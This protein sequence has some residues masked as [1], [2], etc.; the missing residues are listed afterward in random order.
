M[1]NRGPKMVVRA[2]VALYSLRKHYDGNITFY[3]EDPTPPELDEC[4]KCF[5]CN[6]IHNKTRHD[7]KTLVRKSSLLEDP[8]YD[9]TLWMDLDT[10]TVA[11]IDAMFNYLIDKQADV[12]FPSFCNWVSSG[13]HISRR[14]KRFQGIAEDKYIKE[15]LNNHPSVNTGI[16]SFKKS[17]KWE[18]FMS[19]VTEL[20]R[21]GSE[22]KIF[23]PD[24]VAMSILYPSMHEWGLKSYICETDYNVSPIHDHGL[25]KD[26]KI[27]HFHGDKHCLPGVA[28]CKMWKDTFE[29]MCDTNIANIHSVLQYADKRLK[30]YMNKEKD[31]INSPSFQTADTTIVTAC[32]PHYCPILELTFE[33]WRKYKGVDNYPVIVFV[34][35]IDI[36]KDSRLDFLRL[37]NVTM[38]PWDESCM[39]PVESH[40]ELM[41]SAFVF[42]TA[43]HVKTDYWLKLDADSYATDDRPFITDDMKDY[44]FV[45]HKWGYSRPEMIRKLDEW[46]SGHWRKKLRKATPMINEGRIEGRRFYHNKR[47]NISYIQLHKTKFIKFC[48]SLLKTKRLPVPSHDT[49]TYFVCQRFD[50]HLM[51]LRNF[52]RH[53]GFTQ[54]KGK[55]GVEHIRAKLQEVEEM[56]KKDK[57]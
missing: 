26:P 50:P 23:I 52:K 20:A 39:D 34:N 29:E 5:N 22:K 12:C 15:A 48:V 44:A 13:H 28:L 3:I 18:K 1:F 8:P 27:L 33:N 17:D 40:R 54:G 30:I 36:D 49:F 53:H 46:A 7:L 9:Y 43:E 21:K 55:L 4:L 41:L 19:D 14:I 51:S 37:P 31:K 6:V 25:S 2:L 16:L 24:E 42:G 32:D 45:S 56:N 38:I 10:V 11:P 57:K 47:R 35:E